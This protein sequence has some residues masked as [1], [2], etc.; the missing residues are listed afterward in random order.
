LGAPIA[1][2]ITSLDR[3]VLCLSEVLSLG[4]MNKFG[5]DTIVC[6][7]G[8]GFYTEL[9]TSMALRAEIGS[10]DRVTYV[11]DTKS[12]EWNVNEAEAFAHMRKRVRYAYQSE[13]RLNFEKRGAFDKS[14]AMNEQLDRFRLKNPNDIDFLSKARTNGNSGELLDPVFVTNKQLRKYVTDVTHLAT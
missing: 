8:E 1:F 2:A 6:I 12:N 5:A 14:I 7:S 11:E 13:W 9:A 3:W 10:L 4:L